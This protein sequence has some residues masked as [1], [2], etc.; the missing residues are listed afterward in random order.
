M[1][2][3]TAVGWGCAMRTCE[4]CGRDFVWHR[5][6][7]MTCPYCGYDTNPRSHV[8]RN[9]DELQAIER[10]REERQQREAELRDFFD[11]EPD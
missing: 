5:G 1:N 8:P 11:L 2:F 6:R 7:S 4:A 3:G 9:E 10:T